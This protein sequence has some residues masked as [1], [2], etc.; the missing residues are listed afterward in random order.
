MAM[1]EQISLSEN[2]ITLHVVKT[3][4]RENE[5]AVVYASTDVAGNG[6]TREQA[7]MAAKSVIASGATN[8]REMRAAAAR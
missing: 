1:D 4:Y 2:G 5:W 3:K 6:L 8:I 7:M